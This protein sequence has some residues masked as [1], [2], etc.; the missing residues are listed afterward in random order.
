MR[1]MLD[2][3][4]NGDYQIQYDASGQ[5]HCWRNISPDELPVII[6]QEIEEDIIESLID[7][8]EIVGSNGLHYRWSQV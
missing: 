3:A 1:K 7:D 5:G 8:G 2:I 4:A 6:L